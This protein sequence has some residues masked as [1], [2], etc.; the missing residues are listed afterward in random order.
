MNALS[1]N[2]FIYLFIF[3]LVPCPPSLRL[4]LAM[5]PLYRSFANRIV[6]DALKSDLNIQCVQTKMHLHRSDWN[7]IS[8]PLKMWSRS[9]LQTSDFMWFLAVHTIKNQSKCNVDIPKMSRF[10]LA[11][12]TLLL[13]CLMNRIDQT[14]EH[15]GCIGLCGWTGGFCTGLCPGANDLLIRPCFQWFLC[16]KKQHY[17]WETATDG[18]KVTWI[19]EGT[20]LHKIKDVRGGEL[21]AVTFPLVNKRQIL[22][23][24]AQHASLL[25]NCSWL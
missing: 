14:E 5:W 6:L 16:T 10:G 22:P 21:M 2:L 8:S 15:R 25:L 11:V 3:Y 7:H 4:G 24:F 18:L 19:Y 20:P 12:W 9:D 23:S 13:C 1:Q 17:Y